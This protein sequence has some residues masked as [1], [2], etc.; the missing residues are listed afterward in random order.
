M[1]VNV[2]SD[3]LGGGGF[4]GRHWTNGHPSFSFPLTGTVDLDFWMRFAIHDVTFAKTGPVTL[5]I[6]INGQVIDRPRYDSPGEREYSHP[7]P[8]ALL[9]AKN[10]VV[11]EIDVDPVWI[12]PLDHAELGIVLVS[13]GFEEHTP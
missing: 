3:V 13:I 1:Q 9:K 10:P 11:V 2:R 7:V 4:T 5:T 12:A 6:R 8:S